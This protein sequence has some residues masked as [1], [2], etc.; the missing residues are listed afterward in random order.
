MSDEELRTAINRK[1]L[2]N[3]YR[4]AF[5]ERVTAG[6]K[7]INGLKNYAVN[8]AT[9]G[10]KKAA[11]DFIDKKLRDTLGLN[12]KD[13]MDELKKAA[14]KAEYE[15]KITKAKTADL[16]YQKLKK[17][18]DNANKKPDDESETSGGSSK[19]KTSSKSEAEKEAAASK[20]AKDVEAHKEKI[21]DEVRDLAKKMGVK[22]TS[23]L[24][25]QPLATDEEIEELIKRY[26]R[27]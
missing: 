13:E 16:Q 14:T 3:Q 9:E 8:V 6:Q 4:Q 1:N 15:S 10:T 20:S 19:G 27:M 5:P 17:E 2:E 23:D 7:M 11:S 22:L 24:K 25:D 12:V 18:Y 26:D 21:N